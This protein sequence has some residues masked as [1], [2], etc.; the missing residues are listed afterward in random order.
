MLLPETILKNS[1]LPVANLIAEICDERNIYDSFDYVIDHL[2]CKEQ[3]DHLRPKRTAYCKSLIKQLSSG[4]FRINPTDFRTL[5]VNE[6]Y[7]E[8]V[9]Q[10]PSVYHRVGCHAIMVPFERHA[11]ATLIENTAASIKERGMHWLHDVIEKDL[12]ADPERTLYYYQCDIY[13]FYDSISQDIMKAQ[14]RQYTTDPLVLP[15]LDNFISLLPEGL[16]KGLRSSQSFANLHLSPIDHIMRE[17]APYYYRYCDDIVMIAATKK[18][19]WQLRDTLVNLLSTLGLRLKPT[20]AV[21][22]LTEGLDYLGYVTFVDDSKPERK[23]YSRIR[24]RIKQKFCRRLAR[25]KSRKRRTALIGSFFGMAAHADCRHLLRTLITTKEFNKL[26]HRRKMKEFGNF[27]VKPTT[28][29]GKKSFK[30]SCV[31]GSELDRKGVII[32]DYESGVIPRR[33]QD[34]Y[35]RR[36]QAA[37]AQGIDLSLV[38]KPKTRAIISLIHDGRL[39]KLWTG[40]RELL[41]ILEQIDEEDGFPFFVGIELDYTGQHKKINFVPAAK[42]NLQVPSDEELER[43]L[44]IFN[45]KLDNKNG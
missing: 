21:R 24:K 44:S 45:I 31:N 29:N 11:H 12:A 26:K 3:R 10:A 15:M 33:E 25:V 35:D 16:S 22:P 18:E 20:E 40:D 1:T 39:R 28:F 32:L 9:V 37:S 34:D 27:N 36:M 19:L 8:R 30:G 17:I 13:H 41:H 5:I 6:G 14:V 4:E 23:V 42:L 7:K 38:P 2:E 43:T